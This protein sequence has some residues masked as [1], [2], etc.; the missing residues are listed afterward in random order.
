MIKNVP[1]LFLNG[2]GMVDG[3]I[4]VVVVVVVVVVVARVVGTVGRGISTEKKKHRH[5]HV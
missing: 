5:T 4:G 1:L 2:F 3:G